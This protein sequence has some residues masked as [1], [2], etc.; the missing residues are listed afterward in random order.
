MPNKGVLCRGGE[1]WWEQLRATEEEA[2]ELP[3][4]KRSMHVRD[5]HTSHLLTPFRVVYSVV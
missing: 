4:G 3:T 2:A 5:I 1:K